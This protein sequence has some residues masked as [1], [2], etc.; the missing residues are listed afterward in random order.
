MWQTR[1]S[2]DQKVLYLICSSLQ[3]LSKE[4]LCADLLAVTATLQEAEEWKAV[5]LVGHSMGGAIAVHLAATCKL[6]RL[7]SLTVV[8]VVEGSALDAVRHMNDFLKARPVSF[9]SLDAGIEWVLSTRQLRNRGSARV[10]VPSQLVETTAESGRKSWR[11]RV[12][13]AA[14]EPHWAG[15]FE[16]LSATFLAQAIPKLLILA[17][18]TTLDKDLTIGQMQGKF[19]LEVLERVGHCVHEDAP[20]KVVEIIAKFVDR[21]AGQKK[22]I[23]ADTR[24]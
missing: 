14:S 23:P 5:H 24:L 3:D 22:R 7:A 20:A 16:G 11:W 9:P 21:V 2:I 6:P 4:T 17:G 1:V 13:L 10:S 15:W 19:Q 12:D 8:D 18:I